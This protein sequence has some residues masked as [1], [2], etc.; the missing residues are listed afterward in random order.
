VDVDDRS[1]SAF[2][3]C[4]ADGMREIEDVAYLNLDF[5]EGLLASFHVNWLSPV[6]VRHFLVGGSRKGLMYN[7]LSPDEKIK[8]YDKGVQMKSREGVY[9]LLVSY[10][11]GDMWSPK[12]EAVE[13]LKAELQYF[14][15]CIK[16]NEAPINDGRAGLRIVEMLEA[17]EGSLNR[18]GEAVYA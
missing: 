11:S 18:K 13:A 5:G 2:G 10:R 3:A 7:D 12:I 17:A 8:V 15:E 14:T 16:K 1:L 4:H 9:D 6:K